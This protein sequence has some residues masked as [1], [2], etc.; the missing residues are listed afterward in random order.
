[1][2]LR[3]VTNSAKRSQV[4]AV[5]N[6]SLMSP[7]PTRLSRTYGAR[8]KAD[9]HR[10]AAWALGSAASALG[11]AASLSRRVPTSTVPP[12]SRASSAAR[13]RAA[14]T[15]WSADSNAI[16]RRCALPSPAPVMSASVA[17]SRRQLDGQSP[18]WA[19]AFAAAAPPRSW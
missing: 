8:R 9:R 2:D 1:M 11:S 7:K 14:S 16:S 12:W 15:G 19:S 10:S 6:V 18:D 5:S 17:S 3:P 4:I 13:A